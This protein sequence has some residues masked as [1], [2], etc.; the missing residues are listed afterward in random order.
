MA[1]RWRTLVAV[2][3]ATFMTEAWSRRPSRWCRSPGFSPTKAG[4]AFMPMALC[5]ALF[6]GI[7]GPATARV[8]AHRTTGFGM[9]LMAAGLYLFSTLGAGA[10]FATLMPG[11]L[12]SG[13]GAG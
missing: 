5:M 8:G 11:F 6:A 12:I 4:L 2:A 10:S 13:A 1:R 9:L 7:A 3:L